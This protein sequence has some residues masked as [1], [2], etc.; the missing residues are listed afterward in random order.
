MIRF[1]VPSVL[2]VALVG[3]A[4]R[5]VA[6]SPRLSAAAAD[7]IASPAGPGS[8]TP[9]LA[10]SP[11]GRIYM[12]WLEAH[13]DTTHSLRFASYDGTRWSAART[14]EKRRDFMVN[15]ADFTSLE[16]MPNGQIAAHWLQRGR[17]PGA[18]AYNV[19]IAQSRDHGAT[20]S[21]A[22]MPHRDTSATEHGFVSLWGEPVRSVTRPV[23]STSIGAVWLDGRRYDKGGKENTQEMMLIATS[24]SAT[25]AIGAEL[26]LDERVCDCCQTS[27]TV[28]DD[29][30]IIAYRDRTTDEIRDISVVRRV[31]GRW[32]A[33]T[34]VSN[35]NWKIA[36]C[37]VNGP[38]ID[39]IGQRVA[40]A[41][42]TAARDTARVKVAFSANNGAS[43]GMP[44]T[45]DN[46]NP[47]GRVDV[48][49]LADGSALVTWIERTG[50]D[51]A[52]VRVR[53]VY[54]NGR[55]GTPVTVATSSA[56]RASGFPRMAVNRDYVLF[57]WTVPGRPSSVRVA[58]AALSALQ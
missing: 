25:G 39:A 7:S 34:P 37:P 48:A 1:V 12:V 35:D 49:V 3:T 54:P 10:V 47:A 56:A 42:F 5:D 28:T 30:P 2:A 21:S 52:E 44:F 36:A 45:I 19:R 8:T 27:A 55:A 15:W 32:S 41:W 51:A 24:V 38:A 16:V 53:R 22:L 17:G 50:G 9:N 43:F 31:D 11:D 23:T 26:R 58:R 29:G 14:I 18:Y 13:A 40:L 20:W 33:P 4:S 46:G 57:A 6:L